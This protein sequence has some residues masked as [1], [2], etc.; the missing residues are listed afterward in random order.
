MI[1]KKIRFTFDLSKQINQTITY[2]K[3]TQ[4]H[5]LRNFLMRIIY[6]CAK[7]ELCHVL[8][9]LTEVN[10]Y[11]FTIVIVIFLNNEK[12]QSQTSIA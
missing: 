2:Q 1:Y 7:I 5:I 4:Y 8:L 9:G 6:I 3:I 11:I 10:F 12:I